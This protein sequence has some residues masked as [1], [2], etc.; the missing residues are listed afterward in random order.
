MAKTDEAHLDLVGSYKPSMRECDDE[1]TRRGRFFVDNE[2][3]KVEAG[4]LVGAFERGVI[5]E[6]EV[7]GDLVE[8]IKGVKS[9]RKDGNEIT[10]FV[11]VGSAVVDL[12]NAQL[13]YETIT[14]KP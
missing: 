12:L 13:A 14:A 2:V 7:E 5:K 3:A 6:D 11:M 10:V 8:L 9:G 1:A 4:E